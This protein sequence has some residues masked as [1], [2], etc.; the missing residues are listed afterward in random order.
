LD[1]QYL[2]NLV[3]SYKNGDELA[4]PS[5]FNAINPLIERAS[6]ELERFVEDPTKFDCRMI[7]KTKKLIETFDG[8]KHDLYSAVKA[9]V[10]KE[11]ADFIK[12]RSR[13]G[14]L[15][16]MDGIES[17]N[18]DEAGH[19]FKD[20]RADVESEIMYR[21]RAALLA[22]NDSRKEIIIREWSK[23][24]DD[25]SISELLAQQFGGKWDSHRRFITRFKTECRNLLA[26]EAIG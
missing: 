8:E 7:L 14:Q 9:L 15:V 10:S 16:S 4:L 5:I 3:V 20:E 23:G 1:K 17:S 24:A 18:E 12:R 6:Q 25:K 22:Q 2:N 11:K 21:E 26:E 13:R 19:Q